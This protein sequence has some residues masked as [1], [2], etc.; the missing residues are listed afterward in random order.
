MSMLPF[1]AKVG[2]K[3]L[4]RT[5]L[6]SIALCAVSALGSHSR[7]ALLAIVAMSSML[8]WRSKSKLDRGLGSADSISGDHS[9][10]ARRMDVADEYHQDLR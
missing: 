6:A 1:L 10:H 5:L 2:A 9:F 8:W 3:W 4:K 7:G